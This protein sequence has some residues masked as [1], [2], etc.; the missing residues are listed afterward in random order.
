MLKFFC[1]HYCR[2]LNIFMR[3]GKDPDPYLWLMD[4]DPG[5]S[6]K[7]GSG[8]PVLEKTLTYH[9]Q[10]AG[11]GDVT[12]LC[13]GPEPSVKVWEVAGAEEGLEMLVQ[14]VQGCLQGVRGGRTQQRAHL[15]NRSNKKINRESFQCC[16]SGM[17][18]PD[19]DFY[20]SRI[21][22]L[23]SRIPDQTTARKEEEQNF[24]VL[25]FF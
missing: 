15:H 2:P 19:P 9:A 17:F 6:E 4:P 14:A 1:K 18:I 21:P 20:P 8:W 11:T 7:C 16:G 24:F 12:Q 10:N 13:G 3:K 23:G 22:D 5:G 25:P